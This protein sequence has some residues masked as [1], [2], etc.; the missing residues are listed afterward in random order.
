[1]LKVGFLRPMTCF[2]S[3]IYTSPSFRRILY[4][5]GWEARVWQR[6][7]PS[8]LTWVWLGVVSCKQ[9][10]MWIDFVLVLFVTPRGLSLGAPVLALP[11][12]EKRNPERTQKWVLTSFVGQQNTFTFFSPFLVSKVNYFR[13]S[14]EDV[15]SPKHGKVRYLLCKTKTATRTRFSQYEVVCAREPASFW[16]ETQ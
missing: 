2:H 14:G 15:T 1:M 9:C 4:A 10:H 7:E 12:P 8:Q 16:R 11:H 5:S 3:N 13:E 6:W